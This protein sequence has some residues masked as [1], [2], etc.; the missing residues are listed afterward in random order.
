MVFPKNIWRLVIP[1]VAQLSHLQAMEAIN[2]QRL[3][4]YAFL[5]FM[6]GIHS[7]VGMFWPGLLI[8]I[9]FIHGCI[10]HRL[11]L[12]ILEMAHMKFQITS[13]VLINAYPC[14]LTITD[15]NHKKNTYIFDLVKHA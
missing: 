2:G 8:F 4:L 15:S 9:F 10:A 13:H 12:E 7:Y 6:V 5:F 3:S 1:F 11:F 14:Q